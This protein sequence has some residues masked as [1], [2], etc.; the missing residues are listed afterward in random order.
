[1]LEN[2]SL[3]EKSLWH[4]C[5]VLRTQVF[6]DMLYRK[7]H[8]INIARLPFNAVYHTDSYLR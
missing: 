6:A 2:S 8:L 7:V 1:M 4:E 3:P 5:W